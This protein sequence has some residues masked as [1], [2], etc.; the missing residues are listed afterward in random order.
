VERPV[1][2][3]PEYGHVCKSYFRYMDDVL[4]HTAGDA[5]RLGLISKM[6]QC[7]GY[8]RIDTVSIGASADFLEFAVTCRPPFISAQLAVKETTMALPLSAHSAHPSATSIAWPAAYRS[9]ILNL[10]PNIHNARETL[11]SIRQRF[12]SAHHPLA[13]I[14]N[15]EGRLYGVA[16]AQHRSSKDSRWLVLPYHPV[17]SREVSAALARFNQAW[18]LHVKNLN[19]TPIRVRPAWSRAAGTILEVLR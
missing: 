8:F 3:T 15:A 16:S 18:Q 7:A 17:V 1:F 13:Y 5:N 2:Y 10:A 11:I 19:G 4:L 9:R 12:E 14:F 6:K